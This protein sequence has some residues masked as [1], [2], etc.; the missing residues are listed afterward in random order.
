MS[1]TRVD[2]MLVIEASADRVAFNDLVAHRGSGRPHTG[3]FVN[4]GCSNGS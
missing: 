4:A 2:G 3:R 1:S